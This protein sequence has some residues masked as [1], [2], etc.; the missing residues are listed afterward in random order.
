[1]CTDP[2]LDLHSRRGQQCAATSSQGDGFLAF[3]DFSGE[4]KLTQQSISSYQQI[5]EYLTIGSV[6]SQLSTQVKETSVR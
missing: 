4:N 3:V 6:R 1:M 2:V 5:P